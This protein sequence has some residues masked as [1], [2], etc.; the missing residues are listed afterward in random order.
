MLG[1]VR[2]P[3]RGGLSRRF[4]GQLLAALDQAYGLP[5]VFRARPELMAHVELAP[6]S[7]FGARRLLLQLPL[8]TELRH[9]RLESE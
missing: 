2:A 5:D 7:L 8:Q 9:P 4:D 3:P 1:Q 6:A